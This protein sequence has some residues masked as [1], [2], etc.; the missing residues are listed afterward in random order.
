MCRRG[1]NGGDV[2]ISDRPGEIKI[3]DESTFVCSRTDKGKVIIAQCSSSLCSTGGTSVA[4]GSPL[5]IEDND[6]EL[7]LETSGWLG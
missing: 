5:A 3:A 6:D 7:C 4:M 1:W 2:V